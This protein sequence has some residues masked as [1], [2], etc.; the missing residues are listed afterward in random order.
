MAVLG[1]QV[2]LNSSLSEFSNLQEM[3]TMS[4]LTAS[5]L[6]TYITL[7]CYVISAWSPL[8][9]VQHKIVYFSSLCADA[10]LLHAILLHW[11]LVAMSSGLF[12]RRQNPGSFPPRRKK[13]LHDVRSFDEKFSK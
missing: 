7:L 2:Q 11:R 10:S 13:P 6:I 5:P 1:P 3:R 9:C 4:S 8:R 12:F